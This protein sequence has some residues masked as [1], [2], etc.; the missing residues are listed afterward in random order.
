[1]EI[2]RFIYQDN[3]DYEVDFEPAGSDNVMVNATQM[4]K[5]FRK[6]IDFF[7]KSDHAQNFIKELEFTPFGGNSDPLKREEII[8]TRGQSG[9]WMHRILALKFAAWLDT[10]FEL[11][12]YSTIDK[13]LNESFREEKE[14][15]LQKLNAKYEMASLKIE[16]VNKYPE[17]SRYFDLESSVKKADR[18]I[19][20]SIKE[21]EKQLEFKFQPAKSK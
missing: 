12:V 19:I 5:I 13:I 16:M 15:R 6:R 14:A 17:A 11:W 1:M 8:Q 21:Q 2:A 20:R 3:P 18:D 4:A 9:T 10:K 7:L